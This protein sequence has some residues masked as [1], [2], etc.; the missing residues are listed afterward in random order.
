MVRRQVDQQALL[1]QGAIREPW[2]HPL[3]H[4]KSDK[5]FMPVQPQTRAPSQRPEVGKAAAGI[6]FL[7]GGKLVHFSFTAT[8]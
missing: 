4:A 6:F 1:T 3:K 8:A 5:G 2:I 7:R